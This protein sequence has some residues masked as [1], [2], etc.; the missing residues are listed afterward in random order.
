[1]HKACLAGWWSADRRA[2]LRVQDPIRQLPLCP[3]RT[4][5]TPRPVRIQR[6]A[7]SI[8]PPIPRIIQQHLGIRQQGQPGLPPI[9]HHC[10]HAHP[11]TVGLLSE[12]GILGTMNPPTHPPTPPSKRHR[13]S[14]PVP[15]PALHQQTNHPLHIPQRF[16][17]DH[18]TKTLHQPP[19]RR[20]ARFP[21]H[22]S[23]TSRALVGR[24]R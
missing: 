14:R 24:C 12:H 23:P 4:W 2:S 7:M 21:N 9:P 18:N 17:T 13:F 6:K 19:D 10:A 1:M 15:I 20:T 11:P 8:R 22:V 3:L 5:C 16:S